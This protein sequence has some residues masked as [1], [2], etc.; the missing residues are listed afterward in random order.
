MLSFWVYKD[1]MTSTE[2]AALLVVLCGWAYDI[3]IRRNGNGRFLLDILSVSPTKSVIDTA[4]NTIRRESS[5][6]V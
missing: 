6:D 5:H 1:F 2:A 3:A 4:D